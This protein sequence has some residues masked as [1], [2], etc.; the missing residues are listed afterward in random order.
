MN[1]LYKWDQALYTERLVSRFTLEMAFTPGRGNDGKEIT[2]DLLTRPSSYGFGWFISSLHGE[3]DE[4][5]P[6]GWAGY[7]TYILRVPSR[8]VTAVVLTN[9]SNDDA[10]EIAQEMAEI[11]MN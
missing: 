2:T 3:K 1:D 9:S 7:D 10:D 8:R 6:G 11:S 4:E 5:H